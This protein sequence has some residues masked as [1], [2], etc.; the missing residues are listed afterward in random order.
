MGLKILEKL[1]LKIKLITNFVSMM[2]SK[3]LLQQL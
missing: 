3:M 2:F 1:D